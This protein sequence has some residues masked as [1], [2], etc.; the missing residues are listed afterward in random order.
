MFAQSLKICYIDQYFGKLTFYK[1]A[2]LNINWCYIYVYY[3]CLY[4]S[5]YLHS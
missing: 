2:K 3:V 5:I 4:V 1:T